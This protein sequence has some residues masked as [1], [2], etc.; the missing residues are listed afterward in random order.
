MQPPKYIN[1]KLQI[2]IGDKVNGRYSHEP[3]QA[4]LL[5]FLGQT[6][7]KV[8]PLVISMGLVEF[9]VLRLTE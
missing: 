4:K 8:R 5:E 1:V 3:A 6:K 7:A 2:P 9:S